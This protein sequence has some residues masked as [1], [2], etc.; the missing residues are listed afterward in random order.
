[1]DELD[2]LGGEAFRLADFEIQ[3]QIGKGSFGDV[4][5]AR[6]SATDRFRAIKVVR[7]NRFDSDY[8]YE[9]EF[10][11][12]KRFEEVSREHEGFVDILH[13][14]RHTD[15]GYFAY[16]M[17]LADD[18]DA[19]QHINP[20]QYVPKTLAKDLARRERLPPS[21]C[22]RVGVALIEALMELH[23]RGLVHRDVKPGNIIF[24]RGAPKLADVGLVT[25]IKDEP[26]TLVGTPDYM[27]SEVHG[28][29]QGDL[30]SFGKVLY[31]MATGCHPK[32]F[33]DLP[34]ELTPLTGSPLFPELAAIWKKA[35]DAERQH[36]YQ[37]AKEIHGELLAL[38]AGASVLRLKRFERALGVARRYGVMTFAV[39][40]LLIIAAVL[41]IK[42]H[43]QALELRQRKVGSYVAY[44]NEAVAR[45]D[46]LG[47]LSWFAEAWRVDP[48]AQN[49]DRVHRIR[50][51]SVLEHA[52]TLVQM[53]FQQRQIKEAFFTGQDNQVLISDASGRWRVY[54][55][56]S[57]QPLYPHFGTGFAKEKVS[58]S[59]KT[60][61]AV[62]SA[63]T[64]FISLW[65]YE[66]GA[67]LLQLD[68]TNR[69][70]NAVISR[71]GQL[72]ASAEII[73]P[74]VHRI[75]LWKASGGPPRVLGE[76]PAETLFLAFSPDRQWLLSGGKDAQAR[77]WDVERAELVKTFTNHNRGSWIYTGT[78]SSDSRYAA[79]ASFDRSVR[80]W[81]PPS[82]IEVARLMHDDAVFGVEFNSD[83]RRVITAG[84]DFTARIWDP[85]T[86]ASLQVLRHNAKVIRAAFSPH[87][88]LLLTACY[89]DTV[90]VWSLQ[91]P[92]PISAASGLLTLDGRRMILRSNGMWSLVNSDGLLVRALNVTNEAGVVVH[93]APDG[94][95]F[96]IASLAA[97]NGETFMRAQCWDAQTAEPRGA[98]AMLD[99]TMTNLVL[100]VGSARLLAFNAAAAAVLDCGTARA[101]GS[102]SGCE[103]AAFSPDAKL[104]AVARGHEV[105]ILDVENRMTPVATWAHPRHSMVSSIH[106][107][108]AGR[109]LITSYWDGVFN[110]FHA[111]VWNPRDGKAAGPPL[112]HRDGVRYAAFSHDGNRVITCGED[113][114]AIVWDPTTGRRLAPPLVHRE[115]V[116]Y[117][118]FSE[119]DRFIVTVT[120][121][122]LVTI[123]SAETGDPLTIPRALPRGST[124]QVLDVR[125]T[126]DPA[127]LI[128]HDS[129]GQSY[130][131]QLPYYARPLDDLL[132]TAQLLAAQ[133]TDSTESVTPHSK[134][135]LRRI[136]QTLRSKYPGDFSLGSQ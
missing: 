48:Y 73:K 92:M 78:F 22:V 87:D 38:Q 42:Q 103:M 44:G 41:K 50:L 127:G 21:E 58:L 6:S 131:W 30:Y 74:N 39:L 83:D 20:L 101:I 91:Q 62:T 70:A 53:W 17:E 125:F 55:L 109:R 90:R 2:S 79:T 115:Q 107:D 14:S 96:V 126:T 63:E 82:G 121:G 120:R 37:T 84:L 18:M 100:S 5:L 8:P 124:G 69:L 80:I 54:D 26:H 98:M 130:F 32:N 99:P 40:M 28:A 118:A 97:Q 66:S 60:L 46:L 106:W 7:R 34:E 12:V 88:R 4:F 110:P 134:E 132:L 52:P 75:L 9:M 24:V 119:D 94:G 114:V 116:F 19:G 36:R 25:E 129:R 102:F 112:E 77:V 23:R 27:D 15:A 117:A 61:T 123:W 93:F 47:S 133:Q 76:H 108:P 65:N 136:W 11:G 51:A 33:P 59:T 13:I 64:N 95:S 67:K 128:I 56:G 135:A 104:L 111:Q 35:C 86:E 3:A 29:M 89:D 57:G 71:D 45:G 81:D 105:Q 72:V 68:S 1:M 85:A 31:V 49:N 122:N 43:K 16:V 10:A 113:F